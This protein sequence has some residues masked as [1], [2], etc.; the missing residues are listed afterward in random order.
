M[1][2][3]TRRAKPKPIPWKESTRAWVHNLAVN[4]TAMRVLI[5]GVIVSGYG[6][7]SAIEE[8]ADGSIV[9]ALVA[10]LLTNLAQALLPNAVGPQGERL[11]DV[12][13]GDV[14]LDINRR[15]PRGYGRR[16]HDRKVKELVENAATAEA[17]TTITSGTTVVQD[18]TT[19][20]SGVELGDTPSP[21]PEA[22]PATTKRKRAP[23]KKKEPLPTIR[24]LRANE[25]T[26]ELVLPI[27]VKERLNDPRPL[28]DYSILNAVTLDPACEHTAPGEVVVE[29]DYA[30]E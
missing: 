2:P 29:G 26:E 18:V 16:K 15:N 19:L 30:K 4:P 7:Y 13:E 9:G 20:P 10:S 23:R 24:Q 8:R 28:V 21:A 1:V 27:E 6:L 11:E 22:P 12:Y 14:A 25:V 17:T 5:T 3:R